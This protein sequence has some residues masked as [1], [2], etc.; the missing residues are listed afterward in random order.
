MI[1]DNTWYA[2]FNGEIVPESEVRIPF[3]D[4]GF[5]F[6]DAV[7]DTTRTFGHRIFKL[8]EHIERL[9]R[10]LSYLGIDPGVSPA[11]LIEA[12]EELAAR[13]L[14]QVP[15]DEDIWVTQRISRGLDAN[16]K[17]AWPDYPDR[18]V[19][20]E[21]R[22]LPFVERAR[23]YRDG[24]DVI[25]PSFR[26]PAVDSLSPR[27]KTQNYLTLVLG[28]M[29]AKASNPNAVGVLLDTNGNLSEGRGS[30]IFLVRDGRLLTPREQYV[31]PGISRATAIDL[32]HDLGIP[33]EETDLDQFDAFT[34][35]EMFISSTS[36]CICPVRTI[37][38][39][40]IGDGRIPGAVTK[41]LM[42]AYVALVDCDWVDQYL[43]N[44]NE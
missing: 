8:E 23:L 5:K 30:N 27:A 41:R 39:R 25:V 28:D 32:A 6:G 21:C 42:D 17:E 2:W 37:S 33:V 15:S 38:G 43:R 34:A 9:Y 24:L 14:S 16:E 35:D 19:I 20:I 11:D 44:I 26:R 12:S 10:S 3:R 1:V 22:R 40:Q 18:T 29:E 7:F 36:F 4:R 31:L 13:N